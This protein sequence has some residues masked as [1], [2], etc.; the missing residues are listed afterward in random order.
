MELKQIH[1][2]PYYSVP[3]QSPA[4]HSIHHIPLQLPPPIPSPLHIVQY[5][6]LYMS[7]NV[8][9]IQ[10]CDLGMKVC[11]L[12]IQVCDLGIQVRDLGMQVCDL[13]AYRSV[14]LAY[15]TGL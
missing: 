7:F 13:L 5:S 12:G 10:V 8:L 15:S 4:I 3:I 2:I 6:V 14:I 11:D 1:S 9:G